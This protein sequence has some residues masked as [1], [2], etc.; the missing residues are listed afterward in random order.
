M[1]LYQEVKENAAAQDGADTKAAEIFAFFDEVG[2]RCATYSRPL[3]CGGLMAIGF[4]M[5]IY[6][7]VYAKWKELPLEDVQAWTMLTAET[8]SGID[9]AP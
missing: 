6:S 2:V 4:P 8:Q 7:Q 1:E 3:G 9:P 5:L